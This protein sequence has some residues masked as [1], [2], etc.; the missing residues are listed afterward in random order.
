VRAIAGGTE[1]D[2]QFIQEALP[3]GGIAQFKSEAGGG[4]RLQGG[5]GLQKVIVQRQ[6]NIVCRADEKPLPG[7]G[8]RVDA[9]LPRRILTHRRIREGE[10]AEFSEEGHAFL[11]FA[12]RA[13]FGRSRR[14]AAM[15]IPS[16]LDSFR[17]GR[18]T[19]FSVCPNVIPREGVCSFDA[20]L[21]V[22][23]ELARAQRRT[24]L[25][26]HMMLEEERQIG[27]D[28]RLPGRFALVHD[29]EAKRPRILQLVE[30]EIPQLHRLP[31][32]GLK[33]RITRNFSF[34]GGG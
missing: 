28:D 32:Q 34:A 21:E 7:V 19:C 16:R 10:T 26:A 22:G 33:P 11:Y 8:N 27:C 20:V 9:T 13:D 29:V 17:L 15:S 23:R 30:A 2:Q 25:N 3:G 1:L 12:A 31:W 24:V 4:V 6:L 5:R 14:R 18:S